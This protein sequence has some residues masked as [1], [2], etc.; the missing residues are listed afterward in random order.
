M[1]NFKKTYIAVTVAALSVSS[2]LAFAEE[3]P[4]TTTKSQTVGLDIL[5]D[6]DCMGGDGYSAQMSASDGW[7]PLYAAARVNAGLSAGGYSL[8]QTRLSAEVT[9]DITQQGNNGAVKQIDLAATMDNVQFKV[10][11]SFFG[12]EENVQAIIAQEFIDETTVDVRKFSSGVAQQREEN[13]AN[14]TATTFVKG[15]NITEFTSTLAFSASGFEVSSLNSFHELALRAAQN[16][17]LGDAELWVGGFAMAMA[18][19]LAESQVH[20]DVLAH[21]NK[22]DGA[23]GNEGMLI[24]EDVSATL[25]CDAGGGGFADTYVHVDVESDDGGWVGLPILPITQ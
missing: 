5:F 20:M 24:I 6:T 3:A 18:G 23:I 15:A 25:S 1:K 8:L 14:T 13:E 4:G 7:Y 11:D 10:G 12:I 21:Y 17:G 19:T 2:S 9:F 22:Q 16:S